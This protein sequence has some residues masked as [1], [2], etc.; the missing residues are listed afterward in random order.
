[1]NKTLIGLTGKAR[2][3][4]D[5]I[6]EYLQAEYGLFQLAFAS[7]IKDGLEA[8]IGLTPDQL[9]GE[10]KEKVITAIGLSPRQ[11][12]QSLGTEWG[13]TVTTPNLW[14]LLMQEQ[15][16]YLYGELERSAVVSDIRFDDEALLI[17]SMGG[18]VVHVNRDNAPAV[19]PHISE[20]GIYR[21]GHDM[22]ISN[23]GTIA[24]L[25]CRLDDLMRVIT[26]E[27]A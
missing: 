16:K 22:V 18:V 15:L 20:A 21:S 25:E 4:K 7:P 3:G 27:A 13:R 2:C 8:M 5:T 9:D 12:M 24:E 1:M 17:R 6:A 14:L 19:N 11:L 26:Q 23:N 10:D